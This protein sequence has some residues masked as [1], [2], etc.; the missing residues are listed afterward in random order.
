ML[1]VHYRTYSNKTQADKIILGKL[2]VG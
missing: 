2:V 1:C